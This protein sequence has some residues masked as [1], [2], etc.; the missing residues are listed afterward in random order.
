MQIASDQEGT[1]PQKERIT[2]RLYQTGITLLIIY[3][4]ITLILF[5][6]LFFIGDLNSLTLSYTLLA[7]YHQGDFLATH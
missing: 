1:G 5:F 4:V 3:A 7:Q 2:P 6:L